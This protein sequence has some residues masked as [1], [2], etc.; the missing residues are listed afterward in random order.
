MP[1]AICNLRKQRRSCLAVHSEICTICCATEREQSL[2]C[3]LD[4]EYLREAHEYEK[5]AELDSDTIP[6]QDIE[7]TEEFLEQ[8]QILMAYIAVSIFEGAMQSNGATDW[9][10]RDALAALIDSY[11]AL[12]SGLYYETRPVNAY[13]GA[14]ADHFRKQ[15]EAVKEEERKAGA[16]SAI[17]DSAI[18]DLLA[19]FQRLEYSRN[20]GRKRSRAF[21]DLLSGFYQPPDGAG[22]ETLVEPDDEPR[23]IL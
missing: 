14:I 9:D 15:I 7:V 3:P 20:N 5:P 4:C 8:N 13:A 11:R 16:V 19:F 1:C 18:L 2:D 12:Q 21:L 10:V 17:P 22:E 23:I 6:N